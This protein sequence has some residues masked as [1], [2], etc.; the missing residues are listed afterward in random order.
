[1]NKSNIVICD[2]FNR[3]AF[4]TFISITFYYNAASLQRIFLGMHSNVVLCSSNFRTNAHF[5]EIIATG[6]PG[7]I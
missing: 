1:M 6:S 5:D 2:V 7:E 3:Y 4:L